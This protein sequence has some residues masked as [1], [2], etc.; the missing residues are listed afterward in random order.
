MFNLFGKNKSDNSLKPIYSADNPFFKKFPLDEAEL[1]EIKEFIQQ[2]IENQENKDL[3]K[4]LLNSAEALKSAI[5]NHKRL[6]FDSF[7]WT[8]V[9]EEKR[10]DLLIDEPSGNYMVVTSQQP[11]GGLKDIDLE[12]EFKIYRDWLRDQMAESN[13][14]LLCCEIFNSNDVI[15]YEAITKLPSVDHENTMDYYYFMNI[16]NFIDERVE[17]LRVTIKGKP[18][19]NLREEILKPYLEKLAGGADQYTKYFSQDPYNPTYSIGNI[20]NASEMED[21]DV[22]FPRHPLSILRKS[23]RPQLLKTIGHLEE[24][25]EDDPFDMDIEVEYEEL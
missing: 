25:P 4:E 3:V 11:N 21:F 15:G 1:S 23:I 19:S 13:G 10:F 17:Q 12:F 2:A 7:E 6:V 24:L 18:E 9:K 22:L 14:G 8:K 20:R 16:N 5:L